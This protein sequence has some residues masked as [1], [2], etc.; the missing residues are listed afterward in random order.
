MSEENETIAA[1]PVKYIPNYG[2]G[3]PKGAKNKATTQ[4]KKAMLDA[5]EEGEGAAAYFTNLKYNDPK[6]FTNAVIKLLPIQM[7][8]DMRGQID[9]NITITYVGPS[10]NG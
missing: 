10:D 2:L 7:E 1:K 6:T 4:L 9:N 5:L 3:R 8:A